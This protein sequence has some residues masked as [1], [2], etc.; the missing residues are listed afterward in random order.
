M[1]KTENFAQVGASCGG[2][3]AGLTAAITQIMTSI[4]AMERKLDKLV[5]AQE[6]QIEEQRATDEEAVP[7]PSIAIRLQ[8][9]ALDVAPVATTLA[10]CMYN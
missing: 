9:H 1:W 10:G 4:S 6:K 2:D 8:E 7:S 5:A 3:S